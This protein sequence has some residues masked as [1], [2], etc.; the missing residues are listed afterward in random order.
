[1]NNNP[2]KAID[3]ITNPSP[4]TL[5]KLA[6]FEKI[7]APVLRADIS[8]LHDNLIAVWIYKTPIQDC[9]RNFERREEL[10]LAMSEQMSGEEYGYA[11]TEL[12]QSVTAFFQMMPRPETGDLDEDGNEKKNPS[13]SG[14]DGSRNSR[15]GSAEHTNTGSTKFWMK[16]LR[17]V[18][19]FFTDAGR[20]P[21]AN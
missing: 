9:V 21:S 6:L 3:A 17:F 1:M 12:I 19:R 4:L 2:E 14:T 16:C 13:N 15:N 18:L 10:A 8:R 11:L 7:D 5:S 20:K